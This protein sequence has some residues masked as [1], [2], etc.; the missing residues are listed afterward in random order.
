ML[1]LYYWGPH[2]ICFPFFTSNHRILLFLFIELQWAS[3]TYS[4]ELAYRQTFVPNICSWLQ[5]IDYSDCNY[6][7]RRYSKWTGKMT[8]LNFAQ[9]DATYI[10]QWNANATLTVSFIH[11]SY[12]W[13][14]KRCFVETIV[15]NCN[16]ICNA[17]VETIA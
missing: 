16:E 11:L 10:E 8:K 14:W 17:W 15:S 13:K 6:K 5:W 12:G 3:I 2:T 7:Q 4:F 1:V 9:N